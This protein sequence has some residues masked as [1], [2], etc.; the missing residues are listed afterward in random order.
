MRELQVQLSKILQL[1]KD[2]VAS[3]K[4]DIKIPESKIKNVF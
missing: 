3:I 4:L 2:L 1:E